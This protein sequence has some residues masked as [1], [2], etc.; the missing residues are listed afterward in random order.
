MGPLSRLLAHCVSSTPSPTTLHSLV[1]RI[2]QFART[3]TTQWR[4]N[5]LSEIDPSEDV[6][7][8]DEQARKFT[9]P[10]LWQVLKSAMF[11]CVIVL[12][13]VVGRVLLDKALATD[14]SAP[15][16]AAKVLYALR[17]LYFISS[18]LG[19]NAFST[20]T[21]VS[22]TAID[23]LATYPTH[24][25]SFIISIRPHHLTTNQPPH[26]PAHPLDR[27]LDLYFLNT[28]EHFT[29]VL[30]Q[31]VCEDILLPAV[32]PYLEGKGDGRLVE[33]FEAAHSVFLAVVAAPGNAELAGRVIPG[34]VEGA[35][36]VC[37]TTQNICGSVY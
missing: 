18:R 6:V 34:Y 7:Y 4:Q 21:F 19:S 31:Q 10:V 1:D 5:K 29:L 11:A 30:P 13:A 24:A 9:I 23:I 26:I 15:V 16:L 27:C 36:K 28:A 37:V 25:E 2:S 32:R 33:V 22:L 8:L 14:G 12:R 20:Y 3:L 35:F 17:N